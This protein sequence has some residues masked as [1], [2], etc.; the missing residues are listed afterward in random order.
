MAIKVTEKQMRD[1]ILA[2]PDD[3]P[4]NMQENKSN[5]PCG[6]IMIQ[7]GREHGFGNGCDVGMLCWIPP[8]GTVRA[9]MTFSMRDLIDNDFSNQSK[10][11]GELKKCLL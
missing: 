3:R 11:F 9:S 4:I 5:A 2:Q 1:F 10:T 6:C 7:Y 8:I